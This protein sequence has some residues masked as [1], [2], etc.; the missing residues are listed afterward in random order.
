LYYL[1]SFVNEGKVDILTFFGAKKEAKKLFSF[2]LWRRERTKR[3]PPH[4]VLPL[5][6]KAQHRKMQKP[7]FFFLLSKPGHGLD[8]LSAGAQR[9]PIG[10]P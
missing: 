1:F 6:W 3:H 2:I 10:I 7:P 9:D 4:P 8:F 5:Y